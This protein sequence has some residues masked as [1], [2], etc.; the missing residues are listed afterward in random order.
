MYDYKKYAILFVDD[1]EKALK[2]FQKAFQDDFRILTALNVQEAEH[3]IG[4]EDGQIGIVITDQRMPGQTGVDLLGRVRRLKPNIVRMLTTAYTDLDSAIESVNSGAIFKY[5]VKP[6]DL[7][8]LRGC[9]MRGMEFFIVQEE[10]DS[11]LREKIS[12]LERLIVMDRVRS[13]AVLVAGLGHHIRN[14]M[15]ALKT[16]LDLIPKK[17]SDEISPSGGL[18]NPEFW[19]DFWTLAE[20]ESEHILQII[21]SVGEAVV[22]PSSYFSGPYALKEL[23]GQG[24]A[25]ARDKT[26]THGGSILVDI[27]P[28]LPHFLADEKMLQRFFLNLIKGMFTI[29]PFGVNITLRAHDTTSVWGTEG[30]TIWITDEGPAWTET[31]V[32]SLF[33][34][35]SVTVGNLQDTGLDLLSAFFIIHHHSGDIK[36]HTSSPTGPGFEILLPF[37]PNDAKHPSMEEDYLKKIITHSETWD[38]L[39]GTF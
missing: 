18:K 33:M 6:W 17:L 25:W 16:F 28:D 39:R 13:L 32:E 38:E 35:F 23:I 21:D 26:K 8:D 11:L 20:R 9:L 3:I 30:G 2:Y 22:Q 5:I 19:D 36:V 27:A 10:R 1:E 24:M 34:P 12:M 15:T 31:Q 29:N 37:D 4:H 14:P 7:R